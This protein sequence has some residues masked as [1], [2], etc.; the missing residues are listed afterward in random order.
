MGKQ[1][2]MAEWTKACMWVKCTTSSQRLKIIIYKV[3]IHSDIILVSYCMDNTLDPDGITSLC[4][5]PFKAIVSCLSLPRTTS[6]S[7]QSTRVAS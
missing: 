3:K 5:M 7:N 1:I 6:S 2:E 4:R